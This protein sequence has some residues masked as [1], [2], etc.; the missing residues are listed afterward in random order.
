M[1][2]VNGAWTTGVDIGGDTDLPQSNN[3]EYFI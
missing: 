2:G 1:Q 3:H